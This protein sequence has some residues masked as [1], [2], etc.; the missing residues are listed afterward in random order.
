M[1]LGLLF[2]LQKKYYTYSSV[3]YSKGVMKPHLYMWFKLFLFL[4]IYNSDYGFHRKAEWT[5]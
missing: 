3:V 5:F 4:S 2:L 1:S